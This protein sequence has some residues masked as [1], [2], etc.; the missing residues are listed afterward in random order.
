MGAEMMAFM[1]HSFP[2]CDIRGIFIPDNNC[3]KY[4]LHFS[5]TPKTMQ[6]SINP[7]R[8]VFLMDIFCDGRD[9]TFQVAFFVPDFIK[10]YAHLMN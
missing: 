5:I 4:Q 8:W 1:R 2:T 10:N 6:F 7:P 9:V 3:W